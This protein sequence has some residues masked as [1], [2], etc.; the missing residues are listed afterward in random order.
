VRASCIAAAFA[1]VVLSGPQK[2]ATEADVALVLAIDVSGSVNESRFELQREAIA[3]A[4]DSD[5]FAALATAGSHGT[6]EIAIL[7]WAEEQEVILP[8]TMIEG[9][10]DLA[11]IARVLRRA[12]RSWVH[13]KTD[14]A[15]AIAAAYH[16]F[17]SAPL[18]PDRK[19]IDVS[20]DGRQ[21][22]GKVP[23]RKA[24]D[25]ALAHGITV[26][27]LPI[28]SEDDPSVDDWYRD[29]VVGG[30]G[31]FLTVADGFDAFAGAFRRKLMLEVAG[32]PAIDIADGR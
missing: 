3:D 27:G 24:R 7:E 29:N 22:E 20:G 25:A 4:L 14:P 18:R 16:L 26:N 8:W 21:N 5:D 11:R 1:L 31:A 32:S 2:P 13:P 23:T 28:V 15:G 17:E 12:P 10:A 19:V 30:V 6:I 9:H